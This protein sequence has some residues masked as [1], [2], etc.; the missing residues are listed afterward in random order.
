MNAPD[1]FNRR[2]E[3]IEEE[4]AKELLAAEEENKEAGRK[5]REPEEPDL[6]DYRNLMHLKNIF[7][8][9]ICEPNENGLRLTF[10]RSV[11]ST[12]P[13]TL[14]IGDGNIQEVF[15]I[16]PDDSLPLL[17]VEFGS[18]IGYSIRNE[19]FTVWDE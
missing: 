4:L 7:L 16:E 9:S 3:D 8:E 15:A 1:E 2:D 6:S 17:Q 10:K 12:V 14:Q 11:T 19:S 13:E 18:Y 5:G